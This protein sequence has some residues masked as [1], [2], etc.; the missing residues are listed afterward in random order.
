MSKNICEL[1]VLHASASVGDEVFGSGMNLGFCAWQDARG[2]GE[3][4]ELR[5]DLDFCGA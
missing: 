1:K 5:S 4:R 2:R 3:N